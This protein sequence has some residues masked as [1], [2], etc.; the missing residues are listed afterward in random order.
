M[1][2][3]PQKTMLEEKIKQL[4]SSAGIYQYFDEGG[5]LLYIGKAKNL[6][7][8]VKSYFRFTPT[9]SPSPTLS[10]RIYNMISKTKDIEYL[11]VN[12]EHDALILENSLIKQL[13]PK[14]NILLRD[15]KTYPYIYIDL[16]LDYPRFEITRKVIKGNRIKYFG[17][18]SSS[19]KEII[20]SIY[21]L[22]PLVQKRGSLKNKKA[23][24]FYQIKKCLAPCEGKVSKEKY[25]QTVKEAVTILS[26]KKK[27]ISMLE[28]KMNFYAD[29]LLFE[30]AAL[31]RDRINKISKSL[32]HTSLDIAK[33]EDFDVIVL[34]TESQRAC[35]VRLFIR[36]GKVVSSS[37][38]ILKSD[39]GFN[40][41]EIYK[42]AFLE[43]YKKDIPSFVNKIYIY[44][45]FEEQYQIEDVL[46][47]IFSKNITLKV[48]KRGEKKAI[49]E[50]ALKN[51]DELLK[52]EKQKNKKNDELLRE[53]KKLFY[54][55]NT[56]N[57][58]EIFDTSHIQA[59]AIV[60]AMV[61]WEG[62]FK[63]SSYR[64]Y[65][66]KAKNE[67]DQMKELLEKRVKSF[68]KNPPP[69]LWIIDGGAGQLN[70][71]I[72]II[73][74]YKQNVDIIAIAKEKIDAKAHRAKGKAKDTLYSVNG[75]I[76]LGES[77]KR[78]QFI[79][80]LRDEAHRFAISFHRKQ[81]L[82]KDKEIGLLKTKGISEAKIKKLLDYFETFENIKN[83]SEEELSK[84]V[85]ASLAKRLKK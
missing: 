8:R 56:P 31:F 66:L 1:P 85:S 37:H 77:D 7:S 11:V 43:Y 75:I 45:E 60:G 5:R 22:F 62:E 65:N 3:Q 25:A 41:D 63:K 36:E 69:D 54:L 70:L 51:A 57:S 55:E 10:A 18:F 71:A 23:C 15:D 27:L 17:P 58:I 68:C 47:E 44:E 34:K 39:T 16:S 48:P 19:A 6:K 32:I 53:I 9:L 40:K 81:K 67:Y 50:I 30:E 64:H 61:K 73:Q 49:V 72:K 79:Q 33:R 59:T 21:D 24:L 80:K 83:A 84:I 12:S 76:K 4:P 20:D 38:N 29:N 52:L 2:L 35:I 74:K 28:K 42:R 82:K 14:Y 26:D 78:L 13:K 46:K